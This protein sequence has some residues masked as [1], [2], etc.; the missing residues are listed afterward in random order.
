MSNGDEQAGP[1]GRVEQPRVTAR[2]DTHAAPV[3][4]ADLDTAFAAA[5][6]VLTTV[7][8]RCHQLYAQIYCM[9]INFD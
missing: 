1:G 9:K 3:R 4:D 5:M 6:A 8:G 2:A 7:L